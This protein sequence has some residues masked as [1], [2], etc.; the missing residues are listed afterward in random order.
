MVVAGILTTALPYVRALMN[1]I[2]AALDFEEGSITEEEVKSEIAYIK[3]W[4]ERST[5]RELDLFDAA[6]AAKDAD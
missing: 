2:D 6:K 5:K 1:L 3:Q 4:V